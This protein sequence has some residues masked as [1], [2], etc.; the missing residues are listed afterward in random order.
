MFLTS[1]SERQ[2]RG[3]SSFFIGKERRGL[4]SV[5][6]WGHQFLSCQHETDKNEGAR[7]GEK[8]V[9]KSSRSPS[10]FLWQIINFFFFCFA[11]S[12]KPIAVRRNVSPA[13]G[14]FFV[15]PLFPERGPDFVVFFPPGS[16]LHRYRLIMKER[17]QSFLPL[18]S[19][20]CLVRRSKYKFLLFLQLRM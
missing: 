11:F 2:K 20:V 9:L 16:L 8:K 18:V 17:K 14:L 13:H 1:S 3:D 12:L 6:A 19:I 4:N 7:S 5:L 10:N 15:L